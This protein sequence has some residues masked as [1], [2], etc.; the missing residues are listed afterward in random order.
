[1][2]PM[3]CQKQAS[4]IAGRSD[5]TTRWEGRPRKNKT[6]FLFIV[7][8]A[9]ILGLLGAVEDERHQV[10][11]DDTPTELA[12]LFGV[13]SDSDV[14]WTLIGRNET[15]RKKP[16]LHSE[17]NVAEKI[18]H[19]PLAG[20]R[21]VF[22]IEFTRP[23]KK[24]DTVFHLYI[25]ADGD[26]KTGRH[27]EG[28]NQGVDYMFTLIDGDPNHQSTRLTEFLADGG[29]R[30]GIC[31]TVVL[32][33]TLYLFA[34]MA[35]EQQRGHCVFEY[36]I[37]SYVR[38]KTDQ[39]YRAVASSNFGFNHAISQSV[40]VSAADASACPPLL[41]P[42]MKMIGG[43]V[44]GWQLSGRSRPIEAT[45]S[46]DRDEN[47]LIVAPLFFPES[48]AQMVSL[49]PGHYLLRALVK[50]DVFQIHV[51]ADTMRIPVG[52]ADKYQWVELPFYIPRSQENLNKTIQIGFR[53]LARPATGKASRL[54][55]KLY[56]KR[57]ELVRL[58]DTVLTDGWAETLPVDPLH[59]LKLLN[60]Y[61]AW[62]R[63]GKVVFQDSFI[64]TEL[65]LM[66][67]E[68][69]VDHSYVGHPDFSHD[70]KYLHIGARRAPRGL[71]RTDGS[72]RYLNNEWRELVWLFPWMRKRLPDN[73]NP[74]DWIVTSRNTT[75]V[76]LF[77][78][79]TENEHCIKLPSRGGWSIVHY[80][81]LTSYGG[82]G[83]RIEAITHETI[84]WAADDHK[85]VGLSNADGEAFRTFKLQSTSARPEEDTFYATMSSVGG[86]SG[87]NWRD[88]VDHDGN[89]YYLFEINRN[90][91]PNHPTNPYQVWAL[92]LTDGDE[93]GLLRVVFHPRAV[94]TEF[95]SSQT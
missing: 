49:S 55:A 87:D 60:D 86:K 41:N 19:C 52:A 4:G 31:S 79:I 92:S 83:P 84:V 18:W 36:F 32:G 68:G 50:S 82:R 23:Y 78:V 47:A 53:Y 76:C 20:N 89:R 29:S 88:A 54:P 70:G 38:E 74:A 16:P 10:R 90:N 22:R 67:Q 85:S 45:F 65:W 94:I 43:T 27:C 25:K 14:G 64:G 44:P 17:L 57:V 73:S 7:F 58:G 35:L 71:L 69:K 46:Q 81:G 75:E 26:E 95:V 13:N 28:M 2:G 15:A 34:E 48:L 33:K 40:P 51:I 5:R 42:D 1:M 62:N 80:P 11:A 21:Q 24:K 77:N 93:R 3:V 66:T 56:V 72:A 8:P 30:P 59:R 9:L 63:P 12:V 61:P 91:F 39:G 37:M 6:L